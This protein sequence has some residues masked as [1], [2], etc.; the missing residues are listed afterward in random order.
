MT[1]NASARIAELEDALR[2]IL[3][4]PQSEIY[5]P[6]A[7]IEIAQ[8]ALKGKPVPGV[9]ADKFEGPA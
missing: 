3:S 5:V 1:I 7:V 6:D 4:L 8:T 9:I 2:T